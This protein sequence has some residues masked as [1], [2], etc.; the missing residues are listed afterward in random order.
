MAST[1]DCTKNEDPE[2]EARER[3]SKLSS[4]CSG[5]KLPSYCLWDAES[6]G[7][8]NTWQSWWSGQDEDHL[9][10]VCGWS[11]DEGDLY[12]DPLDEAEEEAQARNSKLVRDAVPSTLPSYCFW[13]ADTVGSKDTW[14]SW[15]K[16]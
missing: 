6:V 9:D 2:I 16:N 12:D 15:W 3:N 7:P 8:P 10:S 11:S 14:Q 5:I 4:D 13:T 1:Y